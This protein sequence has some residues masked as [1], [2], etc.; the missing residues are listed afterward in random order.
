MSGSCLVKDRF[1]LL[2][3]STDPGI[4][5]FL[6]QLCGFTSLQFLYK[7]VVNINVQYFHFHLLNYSDFQIFL[8][9][10]HRIFFQFCLV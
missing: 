9:L 7:L 4:D 5:I 3:I 1:C 2:S 6:N 10:K 8:F